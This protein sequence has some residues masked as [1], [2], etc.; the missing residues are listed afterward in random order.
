M[1]AYGRA[2]TLA[3]AASAARRITT[4]RA[5]TAHTVSKLMPC[6]RDVRAD[7]RNLMLHSAPGRIIRARRRAVAARRSACVVATSFRT[8][9]CCTRPPSTPA[10]H[11]S[12]VR[13]NLRTNILFFT[14]SCRHAV[15]VSR[16]EATSLL[17]SD[18]F[19]TQAVMVLRPLVTY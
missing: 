10:G 12:W 17:C 11:L 15:T 1:D 2:T 16:T 6:T 13:D 14:S 4:T 8:C 3:V 5:A 18:P 19:G 9:R 7:F